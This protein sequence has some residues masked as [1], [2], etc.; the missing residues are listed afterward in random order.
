[1]DKILYDKATCPCCGEEVYVRYQTQ[2][3]PHILGL[4]NKQGEITST[5]KNSAVNAIYD[6]W[7]GFGIIVHRRMVPDTAKAIRAELNNYTDT[8]IMQAIKNYAEI[9]HG[10]QYWFNYAWTLKRFLKR[11]IDQFLDL[12]ISKRNYLKT[13]GIITNLKQ[14]DPDKYVKG[15]YGHMVRR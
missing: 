7:N 6:F 5:P 4:V 10:E 8:E 15:K 12:D 3:K 13:R 9:Y 11:G 1:M 2:P 14:E